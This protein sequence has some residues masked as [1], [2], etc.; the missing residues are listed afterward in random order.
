MSSPEASAWQ[1]SPPTLC[2]SP[3]CWCQCW[4]TAGAPSSLH[5]PLRPLSAPLPMLTHGRNYP[6]TV[7]GGGKKQIEV[8]V[9]GTQVLSHVPAPKTHAGL[10]GIGGVE[11]GVLMPQGGGTWRMV[12][13]DFEEHKAPR[14]CLQ[15]V[16]PPATSQAPENR[17]RGCWLPGSRPFSPPRGPFWPLR[18]GT[19]SLPQSLPQ[20]PLT[21]VT[22]S[23]HH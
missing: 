10:A 18:C 6:A 20:V 17:G 14:G 4:G 12:G 2:G 13:L 9:A 15:W 11:A 5:P 16:M 21:W 3:S 19:V 7:S 1:P 23:W 8:F 22:G